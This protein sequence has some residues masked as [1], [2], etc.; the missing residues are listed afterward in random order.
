M[1]GLRD[2]LRGRRAEPEAPGPGADG[3]PIA[4][5]PLTDWAWRPAPWAAPLDDPIAE[6]AGGTRVAPGV[7]IHHD[8][9]DAAIRLRQTGTAAPYAYE[10]AVERFGGGYVSLSMDLPEDARRTMRDGH[11]VQM[12]ARIY[13]PPARA[14]VRLCLRGGPNTDRIVSAFRPGRD[15]ASV[16]EID[17]GDPWRPERAVPAAKLSHAWVD[18]IVERPGRGRIAISDLSLSRRPRAE[19]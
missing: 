16:A 10:I 15:G 3:P 19:M 6:G 13:P 4:A 12:R 17:L 14:Y 18:L 2:R 7:T 8:D 5:P 11:V 1:R 9:P